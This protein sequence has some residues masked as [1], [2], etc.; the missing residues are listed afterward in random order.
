MNYSNVK[1]GLNKL[2]VAEIL[3]ILSAFSVL[4]SDASLMIIGLL[5][6]LLGL[7][8]FIIT[9]AGLKECARDDAGYRKAFYLTIVALLICILIAVLGTVWHN[10]VIAQGANE[11]MNFCGYLV[12][13]LVLQTTA[14]ILR[15]VGKEAEAVYAEKTKNLYTVAIVISIVL[16]A[17]VDMFSGVWV[18]VVA[19]IALVVLIIAQIRYIIL[20]KKAS[21]AL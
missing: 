10:S 2:F 7:V 6:G 16:S 19:L 21:N 17:T 5:L 14:V 20:L 4:F 9:L 12:A 3:T 8:A 1:S 13:F 18:A 11:V 15:K